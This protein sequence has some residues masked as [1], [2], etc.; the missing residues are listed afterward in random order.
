MSDPVSLLLKADKKSSGHGGILSFFGNKYSEAAELYIEAANGFRLKKKGKE[1]GEALEKAALMQL[2]MEERDDAA[3]TLVEAYKSYRK[4][5]PIDAARVIESAIEMFTIRGNFRRAASYKM[6]VASLYELELMDSQK[7]LE[8]YDEAGEWYSNDQ[9]EAL[10]NKAFLKVGEIAAL[11]EQYPLAI[12]KFEDV[13]RKS[14]NNNLMKWGVKDCLFKAGLCHLNSGDMVATRRALE[15]YIDL[16]ITFQSTRE[17]KL[18]EDILEAIESGDSDLFTEKIREYDQL[19]KFDKWKTTL[20]LRIKKS[21]N[22]EP[23]L[24]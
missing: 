15:H 9:A 19:S 7:A 1:A 12:R 17:Y 13:A 18:L 6:D 23:D 21:I 10:A 5:D 4:T 14:I 22:E 2:K 11:N 3:N 24:T 8:S 16:D 20:L